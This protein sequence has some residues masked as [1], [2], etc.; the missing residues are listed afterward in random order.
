MTTFLPNQNLSLYTI[1]LAYIL[2]LAPHVYAVT[3]YESSTKKKFDMKHP[4]GM[5]SKL[6]Q[7]QSIDNATK[8]SFPPKTLPQSPPPQPTSLTILLGTALQEV[9][10]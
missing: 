10:G 3:L 1:P 4:R 2:A 6:S 5:T 7:D 8:G 9:S